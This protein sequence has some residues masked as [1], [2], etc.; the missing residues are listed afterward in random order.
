MTY[1]VRAA[2]ATSAAVAATLVAWW[3][4]RG[5][6]TLIDDATEADSARNPLA[7]VSYYLAS[8][9]AGIAV[10]PFA[11]WVGL[12]LARVRGN[13]LAIIISVYVWATMTIG[14]LVDSEPGLWEAVLWVAVQA[15][16]TTGA[17]L[18]QARLMPTSTQPEER[19]SCLSAR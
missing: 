15:V 13:H 14:H 2:K 10:Q 17:S 7:G 1:L 3:L 11:L 19:S 18:W 8:N 5:M 6:Y 4:F 12:R 16:A 9:A